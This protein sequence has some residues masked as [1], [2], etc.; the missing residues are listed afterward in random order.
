[1]ARI[2]YSEELELA[3]RLKQIVVLGDF[4]NHRD[5]VKIPVARVNRDDSVPSLD[6][7]HVPCLA[8]EADNE[9]HQI[10]D[11]EAQ[12]KATVRRQR[13]ELRLRKQ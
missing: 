3:N 1:M 10:K 2:L 4:W 11:S 5:Q 8:I 6:E 13:K 12:P 9:R 7:A